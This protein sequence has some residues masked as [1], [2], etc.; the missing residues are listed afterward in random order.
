MNVGE[1]T[2]FHQV[3]GEED[4]Q[5]SRAMFVFAPWPFGSSVFWNALLVHNQGLACL[6]NLILNMI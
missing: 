2:L 5:I 1:C 6:N 3:Q 4:K